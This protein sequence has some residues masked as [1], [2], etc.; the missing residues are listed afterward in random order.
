M[1]T[2][3]QTQSSLTWKCLVLTSMLKPQSLLVIKQNHQPQPLL[4][5]EGTDVLG[6]SCPG[7]VEPEWGTQEAQEAVWWWS[8]NK[9]GTACLVSSIRLPPSLLVNLCL[10]QILLSHL[11]SRTSADLSMGLG[12]YSD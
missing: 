3:I 2:D 6:P 5:K 11:A 10:L 9:Q 4:I 1:L 12:I 8:R 7:W